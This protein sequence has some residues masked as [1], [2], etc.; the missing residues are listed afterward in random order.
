MPSQDD[1]HDHGSTRRADDRRPRQRQARLLLVT[2]A[3]VAG[4][5]DAVTYVSLG[6]VFTANMTGNTVLLGIAFVTGSTAR[7]LR[8]AS[9]LAGFCLGV[10]LAAGFIGPGQHRLWPLRVTLALVA[11]TAILAALA[12]SAAATTAHAGRVYWLIALSG[13]AMG[14]QSAAVRAIAV[15]GVATTYITGTL[16]RLVA[17]TFDRADEARSQATDTRRLGAAIWCVY[18]L[19]AVVGAAAARASGPQ[20]IWIAAG[21]VALVA[22]IALL[23]R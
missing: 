10:A 12:V 2:L 15:P 21:T 11:E 8:S 14:A 4:C 22:V 16:T 18:L 20:A 3:V 7:V 13:V 9:A 6:H 19:A 1:E 23:R 5:T 17:S